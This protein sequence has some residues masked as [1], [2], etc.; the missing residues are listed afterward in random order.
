[1]QQHWFSLFFEQW[2][3][4]DFL[5]FL[6]EWEDEAMATPNMTEAQKRKLTLSQQTLEGLR[7]TGKQNNC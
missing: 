1:M 5:R 6:K 3:Q 4:N 7:I 2:L